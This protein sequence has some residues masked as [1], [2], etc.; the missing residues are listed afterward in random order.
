[1]SKS[2]RDQRMIQNFVMHVFLGN[3]T[4]VLGLVDSNI[5]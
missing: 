4:K 5:S 3:I 1:M 2:K